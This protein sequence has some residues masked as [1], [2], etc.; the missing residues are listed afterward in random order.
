MTYQPP[1]P[2]IGD[3][4]H[5]G[6]RALIGSVPIGGGFGVEL[7][8]NLITPPF[9][10]RKQE[11]MSRIGYAITRLENQATIDWTTLTKNDAFI[12]TLIQASQAAVKTSIELKL[13]S[14]KNATL[15]AST[16]SIDA[17]LQH[18]FVTFID[19]LSESH[20]EI[21]LFLSKH[22]E[23]GILA[24]SMGAQDVSDI[25]DQTIRGFFPALSKRKYFYTQ[26]FRDLSARGLIPE[27]PRI[28]GSI[29]SY[30]GVT[31]FGEQFVSFIKSPFPDA[32]QV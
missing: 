30:G 11:W 26:I 14:L 1:D 29:H 3:Y 6:V 27:Q 13:E 12:D 10:K 28:S 32:E 5:A 9:E 25:L 16:H 7:F 19:D 21:L 31:E 15:N 20:L 2:G 18:I 23:S 17:S 8:N 24:T 4:A 22:G